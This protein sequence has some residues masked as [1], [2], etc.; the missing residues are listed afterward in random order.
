MRRRF[1][2]LPPLD[3]CAEGI[4]AAPA[5][6]VSG[7]G[8]MAQTLPKESVMRKRSLVLVVAAFLWGSSA[9]RPDGPAAEA[10]HG[11]VS[12]AHPIATEAGLAVLRAGGNAFDA[13]VAVA[14]TLTVVEPYN[15]GIGGYGL[16]LVYDA[17]AQRARVLNMSGRIPRGADPAAFRPPTPDYRANRTGARA[18]STP[19]NALGWETLWKGY[20]SRPWA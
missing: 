2:L 11:M 5:K 16:V 12:S 1:M 20:G 13:A 6:Q 17:K 3:R 8:K 9:A 4:L 14:T 15:S 18:V 7:G 10:T 19:V